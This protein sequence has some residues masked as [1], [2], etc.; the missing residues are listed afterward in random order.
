MI[1]KDF[2]KQEFDKV[3][4]P[5]DCAESILYSMA[6]GQS[7]NRKKHRSIPRILIAAAVIMCLFVSVAAVGYQKGWLDDFLSNSTSVN[8]VQELNLTAENDEIQ[9]TVDRM[10][11]DGPFLYL[12]VSVRS[13][14][15]T[16]AA[17]A[18]MGIPTEPESG[19]RE[20]L[21]ALYTNGALLYPVWENENLNTPTE[22]PNLTYAIHRLDDGSDVNFCSYT[23]QILFLQLPENYDGLRFTLRLDKQRNWSATPDGGHRTDEEATALI[24]ETF[25]LTDTDAKTME[26]GRRVKIHTLGVQIHGADFNVAD[27]DMNLA[28]GVV[29]KDGTKLP[30]ASGYTTD[31]CYAEEIQWSIYALSEAISPQ[32]VTAVYVGETIYPLQ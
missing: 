27:E 22:G 7:Q 23:L 26:D 3:N 19:I 17:E 16:N 11:S 31:E 6:Q 5:Q 8:G 4:M 30:F 13:Q 25:T 9:V 12:Q 10:L 28:G 29:L 21:Y 20:R 24:E 18:F 2:I 1:M 15:N 32:D 14:G